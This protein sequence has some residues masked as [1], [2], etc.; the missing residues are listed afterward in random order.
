MNKN[1]LKRI[2]KDLQ[3]ILIQYLDSISVKQKYFKKL[4]RLK[5][6]IETKRIKNQTIKTKTLKRVIRNE[7]KMTD[8]FSQVNFLRRTLVE[9][10]NKMNLKKLKLANS[11]TKLF[12]HSEIIPCI[13]LFPLYANLVDV[14]SVFEKPENEGF[15]REFFAD[16]LTP[17]GIGKI[18]E[19]EKQKLSL[20]VADNISLSEKQQKK[21][22]LSVKQKFP[23]LKAKTEKFLKKNYQVWKSSNLDKILELPS[24]KNQINEFIENSDKK[25]ENESRNIQNIFKKNL[26]IE[27][28]INK[29]SNLSKFQKVQPRPLKL[30]E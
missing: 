16:V 28:S 6:E 17:E 22:F 25:G 10:T 9:I 5:K 3:P 8:S 24:A 7:A 21:A 26:M 2:I 15:N 1:I 27:A 23:A 30:G 29:G 18:N 20:W 13:Q 4:P 12:V 14:D 19:Q 11:L